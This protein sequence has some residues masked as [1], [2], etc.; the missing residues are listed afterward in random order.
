MTQITLSISESPAR[1]VEKNGVRINITSARELGLRSGNTVLITKN[2]RECVG[3]YISK[4]DDTDDLTLD[5]LIRRTIDARLGENVQI[6]K[7][8]VPIAESVTI[9]PIGLQTSNSQAI[10]Q[11]LD[12]QF[13]KNGR[14]IELNNITFA[15]TETDPSNWCIITPETDVIIGDVID[16]LEEERS[17]ISY[18][19]LGGLDDEIMKARE[20][21]ELPMRH[22]EI[23]RRLGIEAPKGLLLYG[24]P[25]TGKTLLARAIASE[26]KS[27]FISIKGPEIMNKFYG[28]SEENLRNIFKEAKKNAPSIIFVDELDSIAPKR[29]EVSGEV[30]RRVVAQLLALMD[31]LDNRGEIVVIGATNRVNSIDE[32]LRR[33]GRFDREIEIGV[34]NTQGRLE[35]LQIH[36][37]GVPLAE[38]TD[39]NE[40]AEKTHGY[41]GADLESLIKEAA[42]N[43]LRR[44]MPML[45]L[46]SEEIPMQFLTEMIITQTDLNQAFSSI[47]PSAM[48]EVAI[49]TPKEC[50]DDVGG[51]EEAKQE[52]QEAVEWQLNYPN[53]YKQ[54]K[55]K[56]AKG[57]LLYGVPGTGK[58]LLAKALAHETNSNF[59]SVKGPEIH[60][61]YVGESER[62]IRKIFD[63]ARQSAPCIIFFDEIDAIA[64]LR[65]SGSSGTQVNERV[66][67]Q[68][69]TEIDGLEELKDVVII[70][71]T[72][73]PDI[74]DPALMRA[75]RFGTHI[76]IPVPDEDA[77]EAIIKVHLKDRP[78]D[79]SVK[80]EILMKLTKG[81]VGAEIE[82]LCDEASN[83]AIRKYVFENKCDTNG[84]ERIIITIE[85]FQNAHDKL[86]KNFTMNRKAY[87]RSRGSRSDL[88]A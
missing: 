14:K 15:I 2:E 85:D 59:I 79:D 84:S 88:Y 56:P 80:M 7:I 35:I 25:G 76:E 45:D 57:I 86:E 21:V 72:N 9:S 43:S 48:R 40:I 65:G 34:P 58:T 46:E 68:L 26:T 30:E 32:A 74:L 75:G 62:K 37:R 22:P 69:L 10:A 53:L 61:K 50:W 39:L 4:A 73:R 18:E 20:M 77:R 55:G 36:A 42:F 66:V 16:G 60:N 27:H 11:L 17:L 67:S 71:A 28:Q 41:V 24:P 47:S 78:I 38:D 33:P 49:T 87:E 19:D 52:L 29:E 51:L 3:I 44:C 6:E 83:F 23:F 5:P 1:D 54:L 64:S 13:V 31:G 12:G 70:A 82:S 8:D 63:K 81:M